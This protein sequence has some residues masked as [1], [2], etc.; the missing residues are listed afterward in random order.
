MTGVRAM[1]KI[2]QSA[3]FTVLRQEMDRF[4]SLLTIIHQSLASLQL[5]VKG[6]VVMS[7]AL[8]EAYSD[9]SVK[10]GRVV[11]CSTVGKRGFSRF[12]LTEVPRRVSLRL[13]PPAGQVL[14]VL[15]D[16]EEVANEGSANSGLSN[17]E[18]V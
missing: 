4:N 5:A 8:E 12:Q 9:T 18:A 14:Q 6:E 16:G 15:A 1:Q 10:Q 2:C 11:A 13:H 7:Q 3:L 17:S